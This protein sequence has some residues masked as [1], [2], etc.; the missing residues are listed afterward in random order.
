MMEP[1]VTVPYLPADEIRNAIEAGDW[2]RAAEL[3]AGHQRELAQ[4]LALLD[5]STLVREP[6]RDLLLAQRALL[7]E[8]HTAR[9]AVAE[10]LARL[11]ED[12]RG[13]RAWLRELA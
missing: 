12:H 3:L 7:A 8:L 10:V 4:A 1:W 11:T 9:D 13:A 5:P 6:W 2:P